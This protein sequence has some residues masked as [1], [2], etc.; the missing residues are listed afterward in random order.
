MNDDYPS[1]EIAVSAENHLAV[2]S[3]L[4]SALSLTPFS[5]ANFLGNAYGMVLVF[6]KDRTWI[7]EHKQPG[8]VNQ[9]RVVLSGHENLRYR[10]KDNPFEFL[11]SHK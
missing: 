11:G 8:T 9:T 7:P 2:A 10:A 3:E 6:P 5:L 1:S 4:K